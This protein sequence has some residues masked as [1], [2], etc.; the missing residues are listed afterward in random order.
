MPA[1]IAIDASIVIQ[2]DRYDL[3]THTSRISTLRLIGVSP[4]CV[5]MALLLPAG[6]LLAQRKAGE[7]IQDP[8]KA[9]LFFDRCS[10]PRR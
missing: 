5:A 3:D 9:Q 10:R 8:S 2:A 7:A 1:A 6:C 4:I